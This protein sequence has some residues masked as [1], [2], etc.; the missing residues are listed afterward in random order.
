VYSETRLYGE[1]IHNQ[2]ISLIKGVRHIIVTYCLDYGPVTGGEFLLECKARKQ[3]AEMLA[4]LYSKIC[5]NLKR[6]KKLS[7]EGLDASL[8]VQQSECLRGAVLGSDDGQAGNQ[9]LSKTQDETPAME[10]IF[11]TS[12][13]TDTYGSYFGRNLLGAFARITP[14]WISV[15]PTSLSR[16][17]SRLKGL[18]SEVGLEV[19]TLANCIETLET[20]MVTLQ[21]LMKNVSILLNMICYELETLQGPRNGTSVPIYAEL[22]AKGDNIIAY[23]KV[24]E[25]SKMDLD[26]RVMTIDDI[27]GIDFRRKWCTGILGPQRENM[28]RD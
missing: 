27:V 14:T 4:L 6:L 20:T 8:H 15:F 2:T 16:Q 11:T 3:D 7:M 10:E 28:D 18:D 13:T 17:S 24:F 1:H 25:S 19:L 26:V 21:G 12:S 22:A 9:R 23:C 5:E